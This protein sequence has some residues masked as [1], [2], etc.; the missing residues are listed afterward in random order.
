MKEII[1]ISLLCVT[2]N[3]FA[4]IFIC[5]KIATRDTPTPVSA[6][7]VVKISGSDLQMKSGGKVLIFD[8]FDGSTAY[9]ENFLLKKANGFFMLAEYNDN[10]E[11]L[12]GNERAT[13][14]YAFGGCE[15]Q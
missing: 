15:L 4:S 3:A 1:A 8:N 10:I 13:A 5:D 9:R 11:N 12:T 14:T 6:K 2:G 7:T